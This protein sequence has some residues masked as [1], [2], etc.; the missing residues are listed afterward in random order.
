MDSDDISRP[1]R[2]EKQLR[3]FA[4]DLSIDF[5]SGT[6][7]E[8]EKDP[9]K[10]SE[11]RRFPETNEAIIRFSKRRNPMNHVAVMFKKSAVHAAV[12]RYF[13][14]LRITTF[15]FGCLKRI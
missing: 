11:E 6:I 15:G 1:D 9:K 4:R 8:F 2:Y 5:L 7:S 12:E 13:T 3:A 14:C 10:P